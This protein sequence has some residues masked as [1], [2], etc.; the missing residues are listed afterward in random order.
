MTTGAIAANA[1][2]SFGIGVG[3]IFLDDLRCTG[4]ETRLLDCPSAGLGRHNCGHFEDVAVSCNRTETPGTE[5]LS[6]YNRDCIVCVGVH[7][8]R[9]DFLTV[10]TLLIV[11]LSPQAVY[12]CYTNRD[13]FDNQ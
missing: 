6:L 11:I 1:I 9:E 8:H 3:A 13:F 5:L 12:T 2:L 4:T 7:V 10:T